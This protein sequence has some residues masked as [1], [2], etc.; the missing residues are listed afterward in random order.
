MID[1][2]SKSRNSLNIMAVAPQTTFSE[3]TKQG[4]TICLPDDT[5]TSLF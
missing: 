3:K 2:K 1:L 5:L 4:V